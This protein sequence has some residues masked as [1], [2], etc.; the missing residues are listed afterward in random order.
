MTRLEKFVLGFIVVGVVDLVY[1]KQHPKS[2]IATKNPKEWVRGLVSN[3]Q[4]RIAPKPPEAKAIV[5]EEQGPTQIQV[6]ASPA[7]GVYTSSDATIVQV[8]ATGIITVVG[9]GKAEVCYSLGDQKKCTPVTI[10]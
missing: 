1:I 2:D 3:V 7:G 5:P 9:H 10:P 4:K 6:F 8:S